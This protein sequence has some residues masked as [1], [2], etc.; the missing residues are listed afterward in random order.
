MSFLIEPDAEGT[1]VFLT[2]TD[3]PGRPTKWFET[4]AEAAA[5]AA[6]VFDAQH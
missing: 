6:E 5:A 2:L 3:L 4:A 1:G